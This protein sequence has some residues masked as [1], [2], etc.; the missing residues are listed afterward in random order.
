[1]GYVEYVPYRQR[2]TFEQDF[3]PIP[4][5]S[6]DGWKKIPVIESPESHEKLVPIGPFSPYFSDCDASAVY[7]G[8]RGE[9][10]S[11]N[12]VGHPIDRNVSL[13]THYVR[14][15]VLEKL[16]FAQSLLPLGCYFRLFD[17]YRP[18]EVQQALFD[19]QY[20]KSFHEHPD[21]SKEQL[22]EQTQTYVS[23]PSPDPKRGTTHPSPHSTGG[24]VDLTLIRLSDE[25]Q[26]LLHDLNVRKLEG[27]LS[28][29]ISK[30]EKAD[31]DSV[32]S[33]I[34]AESK[35]KKWT[36]ARKKIVSEHW[37]A[38][39][40]YFKEKADIFHIYTQELDMGTPFDYFGPEANTRY[41]E[42]LSLQRELNQREKM[43]LRHRR[44]FYHVMTLAGFANY[45]EEYWHWS[46][47]DNMWAAS[48]RNRYAKYGVVQLNDNN[49]TQEWA[50]RGVHN[51]S[52][53]RSR[54][55]QD[56]LFI[57]QQEI[58]PSRY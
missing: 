57:P 12:F 39:Y 20:E 1:M 10:E 37:L 22:E 18:L 29:P 6:V 45:E 3:K 16:R 13:L 33:W 48:T 4:L 35:R 7:F 56:K 49:K 46:I 9:G 41:Y 42:E 43:I 2:V 52:L 47:K 32:N 19:A 15:D 31:Y 54:N 17:T 38:Q 51:D 53:T 14:E 5:T 58:D 26:R 30:A 21:W 27:K 36:K 28:Y 40:R 25:G 34:N 44:L 23:L 11:I 55:G 50:R 8:E 24:V